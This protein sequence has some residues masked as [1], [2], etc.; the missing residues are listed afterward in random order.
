M[1]T[2]C[3]TP[4]AKAPSERGGEES[5]HARY[6]PEGFWTQW[7]P[8]AGQPHR[9]RNA[10]QKR[11]Q[12]CRFSN[13]YARPSDSVS[14]FSP[15]A[16]W[17]LAASRISHTPS[18]SSQT[19]PSAVTNPFAEGPS[20][21]NLVRQ[22]LLDSDNLTYFSQRIPSS[23]EELRAE[24][25]IV[26]ETFTWAYFDPSTPITFSNLTFLNGSS[27]LAKR[28]DPSGVQAQVAMFIDNPPPRYGAFLASVQQT[29]KDRCAGTTRCRIDPLPLASYSDAVAYYSVCAS[30][31]GTI[32]NT[33]TLVVPRRAYGYWVVTV[34]NPEKAPALGGQRPKSPPERTSGSRSNP[35]R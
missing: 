20:P 1:R 26:F 30:T 35:F 8:L 27:P 19:L 28:L 2:P 9:Q 5:Y 13:A 6:P 3:R 21:S 18:K 11:S 23:T 15:L 4:S 16:L 34:N 17:W 31:T 32:R 12:E 29:L 33:G 24:A 22:E 14:F 25:Q 7:Q 10:D